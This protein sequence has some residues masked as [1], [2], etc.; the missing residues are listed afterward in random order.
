LITLKKP[1]PPKTKDFYGIGEAEKV[2][3]M[4]SKALYSLILNHNIYKFQK[5]AHVYVPKS[6][7]DKMFNV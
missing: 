1:K 6:E 2:T 4:S 3:G 7:I 5:C